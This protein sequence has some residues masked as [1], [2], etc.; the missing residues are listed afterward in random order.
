MLLFSF[1]F[2]SNLC[3]LLY[4]Y[5]EART[6]HQRCAPASDAVGR[7]DAQGTPLPVRSAA[8]GH[9]DPTWFSP[10]RADAS[11]YGFDARRREPIRADSGLNRPESAGIG[12]Y[13]PISA[14]IAGIGRNSRFRPKFKKKKKKKTPERTVFTEIQNTLLTLRLTHFVSVLVCSLPLCLSVS[15]PSLPHYCS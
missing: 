5:W 15:S 9:V 10:T 8:S 11:R 7:G 1:Y 13:R 14:G 3:F 12:R 4:N 6:R 2:G